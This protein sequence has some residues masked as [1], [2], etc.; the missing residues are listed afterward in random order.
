MKTRAGDR[1][2]TAAIVQLLDLPASGPLAGR[3]P[4]DWVRP[5]F[6]GANP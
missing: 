2:G 5:S 3:L 6:T 4:L 1:P